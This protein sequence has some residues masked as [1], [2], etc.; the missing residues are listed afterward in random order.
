MKRLLISSFI[1]SLLM[2]VWGAV[3]WQS[4]LPYSA[5]QMVENQQ[6]VLTELNKVL[7]DPG[8]YV[9][10]SAMVPDANMEEVMAMYEQ[11]PI[12]IAQVSAGKPAFDPIIFAKGFAHYLIIA[13]L[14]GLAMMRLLPGQLDR[15]TRKF[16]LAFFAALLMVVFS[17]GG[18]LIWWGIPV[19]W[20]L[21]TALYEFIA[22][23]IGGFIMAIGIKPAP[24]ID[25]QNES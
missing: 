20:T 12:I 14:L 15:F 4:P 13:I 18:E 16:G 9:L 5:T 2:F 22:I 10:P 1:A 25:I 3:F 21:W 7:P 23:L 11:G 19:G 24:Q 8:T 17:H 6:Q